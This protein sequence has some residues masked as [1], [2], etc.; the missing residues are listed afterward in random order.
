MNPQS[1]TL[2]EISA[3]R[4]LY[5]SVRREFWESR[6]LYIAPLAV[7]A[8]LLFG[9]S[10]SMIG[11]PHRRRAV[12]M[13]DEAQ[14]RAAIEKPYAIA[15]G[16]ILATAFIVGFF[17]CL[18]ALHGERR[19]RSILLFDN[20]DRQQLAALGDVRTPSIADLFVAVI[21]NQPGQVQGAVR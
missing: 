5:W 6:S 8:V 11:L 14:Q 21:G 15:A 12:L 19:G 1:E 7:A 18:D 13:L 20:A 4:R 17:Y 16:M 3:S 9:L 2:S 10:L